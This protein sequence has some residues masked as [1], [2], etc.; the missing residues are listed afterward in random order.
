MSRWPVAALGDLCSIAL[1]ATPPRGSS[2]FWDKGKA[3]SNVWLSIADMP[4]RLHAAVSDSKEYLSNEGAARGKIVKQ[5]TLLVSF[6]LTLGR[7]AYAGC[8][9]R[10]NEAIA[11]LSIRDAKRIEKEYLY[12]YLTYFDWQKAAEG[13]DKV[14]GKTLNKE[15][16]KVLPVLVPPLEEQRRIV[17]VLDEAFAAIATATANAEKNLAN[18]RE[19]FDSELDALVETAR[20]TFAGRALADH[21]RRVTVGHVGAMKDRYQDEGIPFLRSQNIRPFQIELDGVAFIDEAF[22]TEL[23]KSRLTPGDVAVVRTGY[24]GTAAVIPPSLPIS[25]CADLVII[26]PGAELN[27]HYVTAFLNSSLGKR[28]IAGNLVG[29]A[30]KHFNVGAAKKVAIPLPPL[31]E[32][33]RFVARVDELRDLSDQLT[34][35][36]EHKLGKLTMLKQA[37]LTRAFSGE[38]T[39]R[40]PLAA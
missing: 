4:T 3:T 23:V 2:R 30:Q 31:H 34:K 15:K 21:C 33:E 37:A 6:K 20:T 7:L 1:G 8:D 24:P 32:Q 22:D 25:N 11:A 16:L 10:T 12:W 40:E 27:P 17:A 19:L 39:Q 18:A 14:K 35:V 36:Y 9:L 26:R 5:G 13:E 29:A 38:L 28:M